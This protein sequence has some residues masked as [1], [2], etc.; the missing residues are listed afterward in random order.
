MIP[1]IR[2][3]AGGGAYDYKPAAA[4][5]YTGVLSRLNA[6]DQDQEVKEC[7]ITCM[8]LMLA[9]LGDELA[10]QLP[11]CLPMLLDRLRNEITRLAA[12]KALRT[13]SDSPLALDLSPVAEAAVGEL[14][15]F[16]RKSNRALRRS[17]LEALESLVRTGRG[18]AAPGAL[19]A[20]VTEAAALVTDADL[21]V[22]SLALRLINSMLTARPEC[23]GTVAG[24]VLPQALL[25]VQSPGL[26]GSALGALESFFSLLVASPVGGA[27]SFEALR[28]SLMAAGR[29]TTS[30]ANKQAGYSTSQC[31]ARLC[32]AAGPQ[33]CAATVA[34]LLAD[35][36]GG[37]VTKQLLALLCLGALGRLQDLGAQAQVESLLISA[38]DAPS[39][40]VKAAASYAL[41][42]V[43]AGSPG[44]Y[45]PFLLAQIE[46]QP[47]RQYL[48][49]HSLKEVIG[50]QA[51]ATGG[52][53][54]AAD[55][56]K[57]RELLFRYGESEEEGVR[58]VVAECLG[59]LVASAPA[60]LVPALEGRLGEKSPHMRATAVTALKYALSEKPNLAAPL[61]PV[62]GPSMG[63][64]LGLLSDD[65]RH[66]RRAAVQ[67]LNSAAHHKPALVLD[68]LPTLLPQL[69]EQTVVRPELIR[70]VDLGPFKHVVDDGLELRK[71]AYECVD[72]L[73]D[74]CLEGVDVPVLLKHLV[75]GLGDHYDVKVPCHL[76][77][78]KMGG[79]S[80]AAVMAMLEEILEPV[81]KT[82]TAKVKPDAVK[83]EV[84]R[85]EDM[86]RSALRA[87]DVVTR[88][89][90]AE[91][92]AKLQDFLKNIVNQ[93]P[94]AAR[95]A[96]VRVENEN[97]GTGLDAMEIA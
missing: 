17:S 23:A 4:A 31:M 34:A 69:L 21:H 91:H 5:M 42:S 86:F 18:A 96:A 73:L 2:P 57:V 29:A 8:G 9:T 6:Q 45:L 65:D 95:Y 33:Q 78:G 84:D 3:A 38:M 28:D 75:S 88:I 39:E 70:T 41:G 79:R 49:L 56:A 47:K 10:S 7:A 64:F 93:G 74:R 44:T 87:V 59:R 40:E 54:S 58:N 19:E 25:L 12:V 97:S 89:P 15:G 55:S 67:A 90:G 26:Q 61:D 71:A 52:G 36:G 50:G 46:A 35:V 22:A 77:L 92:S 48:L 30:S 20:V 53:I 80:G 32:V 51:T 24:V 81:G 43:A 60:E 37:G 82:L 11:T 94:M 62:V 66:V 85:N 83:Q 63:R 16:L 76:I 27:A 68:L 13:A 72:S 14:T 1:V